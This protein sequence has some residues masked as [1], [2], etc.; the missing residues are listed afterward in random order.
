M[1]AGAVEDGLP[2]FALEAGIA[3]DE[4]AHHLAGVV[5]ALAGDV[6]A[7]PLHPRLDDGGTD[8]DVSEERI[9]GRG[10]DQTYACGRGGVERR[11][12][13][14]EGDG[15]GVRADCRYGAQRGAVDEGARD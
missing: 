1:L 6:H 3:I 13:G 4:V 8:G 9:C 15:E 2:G 7:E 12:G 14:D 11:V 10:D 5:V